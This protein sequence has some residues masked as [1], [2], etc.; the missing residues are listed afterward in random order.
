[1][2]ET[3]PKTKRVGRPPLSPKEK[4]KRAEERKEKSRIRYAERKERLDIAEG[5]ETDAQIIAR[6]EAALKAVAKGEPLPEDAVKAP[7]GRA[8]NGGAQRGGGRP[9]G[10]R[11]IYSYA[12]VRK[13]E[14]LGFDPL[15]KLTELY[16]QIVDNLNATETD[17]E[18]QERPVVKIGSLAHATMLGHL[19]GISDSLAKYSYR[20]V[21]ERREVDMVGASTTMITLTGITPR[22]SHGTELKPQEIIEGEFEDETTTDRVSRE[23][24]H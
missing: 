8:N 21:P 10:S 23:T 4:A 17:K 3:K 2:S 1:M 7:D 22:E 12:S 19:K 15:E 14:E 16:N 24:E 18:G 5:R 20:A 11:R 13:M 6:Q 9:K